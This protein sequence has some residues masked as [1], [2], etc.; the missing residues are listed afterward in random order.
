MR[1][2][3]ASRRSV[4]CDHRRAATDYFV[5]SRRWSEDSRFACAATTHSVRRQPPRETLAV[6][7]AF[8]QVETA[9]PGRTLIR[10]GNRRWAVW[11]CGNSRKLF[12]ALAPATRRNGKK[13]RRR[14]DDVRRWRL[15]LSAFAPTGDIDDTVVSL[16]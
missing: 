10:A 5:R 14:Q 15:E 9:T 2:K 11:N 6:A 7:M 1:D 4:D 8:L 12:D 3:S 16:H 13:R